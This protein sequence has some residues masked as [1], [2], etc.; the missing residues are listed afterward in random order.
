M[1]D[2]AVARDRLRALLCSLFSG[3]A[4]EIRTFLRFDPRLHPLTDNIAWERDTQSIAEQL[5][6]R[7]EARGLIAEGLLDGLLRVR[8]AR[9]P[10][11]ADVAT[12]WGAKLT[13]TAGPTQ[14]VL[15]RRR[16][17]RIATLGAMLAIAGLTT[18][19]WTSRETP[20]SSDGHS[21]AT[22][23]DPTLDFVQPSTDL[24]APTP[25]DTLRP[26]DPVEPGASGT[27]ASD[28]AT[29]TTP[30]KRPFVPPPA[31]DAACQRQVIDRLRAAGSPGRALRDCWTN[32]WRQT[33]VRS[34]TCSTR[35]ART[36]DRA[37]TLVLVEPR[38]RME[39]TA[40]IEKHSS[41]VLGSP[42]Q[43]R[44]EF[45]LELTLAAIEPSS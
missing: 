35:V 13:P 37:A 43:C 32:F 2:P 41:A 34:A 15:R 38:Q 5:I 4:S 6:E 30:T 29:A 45:S 42:P 39:S 8:P 7:C 33:K 10:E 16:A 23:G 31:T 22:R 25:H 44:R 12:L 18:Y 24:Q 14:E 40:C 9:A 36:S 27:S 19:L 26:P 17:S 3:G 21:Q 1:T 20:R 11:I 28:G